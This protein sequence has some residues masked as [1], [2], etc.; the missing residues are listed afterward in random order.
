MN[1]ALLGYL[2]Q[3]PAGGYGASHLHYLVSPQQPGVCF[4]T[5]LEDY[6]WTN[7]DYELA[8]GVESAH[9]S[10][11]ITYSLSLP[12]TARPADDLWYHTAEDQPAC[13]THETKANVAALKIERLSVDT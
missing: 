7:P 6:G 13:E 5:L 9:P 2:V 10:C 1:N 12:A 3:H 8:R 4:V 11:G